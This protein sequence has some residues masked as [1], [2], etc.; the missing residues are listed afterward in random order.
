MIDVRGNKFERKPVFRV[1]DIYKNRRTKN[2]IVFLLFGTDAVKKAGYRNTQPIEENRPVTFIM[3]MYTGVLMLQRF[4]WFESLSCNQ[5][6]KM[7][8]IYFGCRAIRQMEKTSKG[9]F[10]QNYG[11]FFFQLI[12]M[13]S[14]SYI[15]RVVSPTAV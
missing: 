12:F 10:K 5:N 4:P 2:C 3:N 1:C 9:A 7:N 15:L 6:M 8:I 14:A 11:R 13:V